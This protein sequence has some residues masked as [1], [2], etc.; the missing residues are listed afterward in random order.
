M[1]Y[2]RGSALHGGLVTRLTFNRSIKYCGDA[3]ARTH[4]HYADHL[5]IMHLIDRKQAADEVIEQLPHSV[6][7]MREFS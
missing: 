4:T 6:E 7:K 3:R 1:N 2:G 5:V